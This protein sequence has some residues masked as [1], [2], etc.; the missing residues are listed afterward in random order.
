MIK[1]QLFALTVFAVIII[2]WATTKTPAPGPETVDI[3]NSEPDSLSVMSDSAEDITY[4][5][6]PAVESKWD[7][8]HTMLDLSF[9]WEKPAVIGTA[10]LTLSPLLYPQ[11]ELKFNAV[12]FDIKKI[13]IGDKIIKDLKY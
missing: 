13:M 10:T 12:D 7:L 4:E 5:Y 6:H 2:S 3:S 9:D 1:F 8:L 11:S